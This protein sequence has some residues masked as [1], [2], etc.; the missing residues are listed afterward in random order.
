MQVGETSAQNSQGFVHVR[1]YGSQGDVERVCDF[2]VLHV[3]K[4]TELEHFFAFV[5][6]FI[7]GLMDFDTQLPVFNPFDY[8]RL[9]G[10][11]IFRPFLHQLGFFRIIVV[12]DG[13]VVD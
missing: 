2:F 12:H 3:V 9:V 1:F 8:I 13:A 4:I 6:Q 10:L 5:R 7:Y 11:I